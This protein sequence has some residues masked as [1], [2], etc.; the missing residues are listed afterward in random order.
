MQT[1][2]EFTLDFADETTGYIPDGL[3]LAV[4]KRDREVQQAL[5]KELRSRIVELH[6][7]SYPFN[8]GEAADEAFEEI[9]DKYFAA[10]QAP[11]CPESSST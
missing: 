5:L 10:A 2:H 8:R 1:P 3:E 4:V 7:K 9:W 11:A 6:Q